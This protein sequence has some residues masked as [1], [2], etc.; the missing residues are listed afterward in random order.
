MFHEPLIPGAL[1][2]GS[3]PSPIDS[4]APADWLRVCLMETRCE[5]FKLLRTPHYSL[6]TLALPV[7][8]YLL[9]GLSFTG[10]SRGGVGPAEYLM[11]GYI[12]F[13]VVTASLFA[14]GSG[15]ALERAQGWLGL[16]RTTPMPVSAYLGAKVV[17]CMLFGVALLALMATVAVAFGGVRLPL[18][19]WL[20]LLPVVMLGCVPFCLAGLCIALLVPPAGASGIVNLLNLPLAFAGG[21]WI[22]VKMLPRA[23]QTI[24]PVVPQYHIAQLAAGAIGAP[25]A[26]PLWQHVVMLLVASVVFGIASWLAWRRSDALEG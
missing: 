19:A 22:P 2:A 4:E 20:S 6:P 11:A 7:M 23:F 26:A 5:F 25:R 18:A 14:F 21:L 9:F 10:R 15:V 12:V 8:F 3:L 16:K 24:A 13:G 1:V 17:S